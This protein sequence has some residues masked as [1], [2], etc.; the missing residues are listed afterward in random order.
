[1][2]TRRTFLRQGLGVTMGLAADKAL[3]APASSTARP[4]IVFILAD[5]LG[6]SDIGPY[7]SEVE[8]PNLD[9]LAKGG[10][11]FAQFYN[12]PR[13]CPSRAALLTGMYSHQAQMG[14]MVADYGRYA[15]PAYHG[16]LSESCVTIAEALQAGGYHT[17]MVGKWHLTP[18]SM[19]SKHNWPLQR[20]FQQYFGIINGAAEYWDPLSLA[21][22]NEFLPNNHGPYLTDRF[23]DKAVE[24]IGEAA[25]GDKPFFLYLAFNAPH[26]PLQAPEE[27]IAKYR[28]RY[29][30]GWDHMRAKRHE[31]QVASGL[32]SHEWD[33]TPRDP[34]VPAWE[35]AS[36]H[37]WEMQRMAVYAAMIDRM[38]QG[39]GKV[40]A[41]LEAMGVA[42]NTLVCFMSDNG[43]NS[44]EMGELKP[45]APRPDFMNRKLPDGRD[46]RPGNI[47]GLMPGTADTFQSIGIPWGNV[48]NTPFR[49]YKHYTHEGGISTPFLMHWPAGVRDPGR[50]V[51]SVGHEIDVMPTCL[52]LAGCSLPAKSKAGSV[53][54][55]LEGRSLMHALRNQPV[56]ERGVLC[57]E[58]EGNCAIRKGKWKLVSR[59]PDSWELF[60][61]EGDRTELRN[62]ADLHPELT[63]SLALEY[64]QWADRV[65]ARS[66]PMPETPPGERT[67]ALLSPEYLR[68]D[69][70]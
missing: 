1:M 51:A 67:G 32:L 58:H 28:D 25:H 54:A 5:D 52:E 8:T 55:P 20:G 29:R 12:S 15:A 35:R 7:G 26:W 2:S 30:D 31:R 56:P 27:T 61:M 59:F 36:Y 38:D 60:D 13:C 41:K 45:N 42:D 9:R 37:D 68:H 66:W 62:V 10:L 23:A 44:E 24:Y 11:R 22:G 6:F 43:G 19:P 64:H 53:P 16:D 21:E 65:G 14:D 3:G 17:M 40:M 63:A 46:V 50:T 69:R 49:L 47:P 33:M 39:I 18:P 70:P 57:W 48:S 4:N 34:R